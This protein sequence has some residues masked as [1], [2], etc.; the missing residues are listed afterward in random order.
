MDYVT[1]VRPSGATPVLKAS[2]VEYSACRRAIRPGRGHVPS[3][4]GR[5]LRG[6]FERIATLLTEAP[7]IPL[8]RWLAMRFFHSASWRQ[9]A[10]PGFPP[11]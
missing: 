7:L 11:S 4:V 10:S 8:R 6:N 5:F 1:R 2:A 9:A 3:F